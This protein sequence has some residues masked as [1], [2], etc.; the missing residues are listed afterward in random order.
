MSVRY[1]VGTRLK[2]VDYQASRYSPKHFVGKVATVHLSE[3]YG[4]GVRFD[5]YEY[6][7]DDDQ[8][9]IDNFI[10]EVIDRPVSGLCRFLRKVEEK[11]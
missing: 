11:T 9:T 5:S 2:C 4:L 8:H 1:P 3:E 7:T 6:S 10:W